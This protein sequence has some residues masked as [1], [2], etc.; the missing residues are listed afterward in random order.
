MDIYELAIL[1]SENNGNKQPQTPILQPKSNIP[2]NVTNATRNV[3]IDES[4]NH[5]QPTQPTQF[6]TNTMTTNTPNLNSKIQDTHTSHLTDTQLFFNDLMERIDKNSQVESLKLILELLESGTEKTRRI[7]NPDDYIIAKHRE[8][9]EENE[10]NEEI[11][12]AIVTYFKNY[13][14]DIDEEYTLSYD[15]D[16]KIS[17]YVIDNL[18][19][20]KSIY[21]VVKNNNK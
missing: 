13:N 3:E 6:N 19:K 21:S 10:E 5:E 16:E 17:L 14:L 15:M 2:E 4:V 11:N 8:N 18:K 7:E 20:T 12:Q 9:E 1:D